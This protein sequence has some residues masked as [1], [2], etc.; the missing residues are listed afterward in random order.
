V[1]KSLV[2]Q[3]DADARGEPRFGMLE[4]IREFALERLEASGE[5]PEARRRH[6]EHFVALAEEAAP[7]LTRTQGGIWLNRL[8]VEHDN[9]RAALVW[10]D[11]A[12]D[13]NM[14]ARLAASLWWFWW[15]RGHFEARRWL[16]RALDRATAHDARLALLDGA[17]NMALFQ[18]EHAKS[19]ELWS[20]MVAIGRTCGNQ[21]AVAQS[22]VARAL[23]RQAYVMRIMGEMEQAVAASEE[24]IAI[25][26]QR[27]DSRTTAYTLHGVAQVAMGWHDL[28]GAVTAWEE[29]LVRFREVDDAF[30]VPHTLC[31]LGVVAMMRGR[32]DK[33]MP[34][35]SEALVLMRQRDDRFALRFGLMYMLVIAQRLGDAEQVL[36]LAREVLT[37]SI[38]QDSPVTA[39]NALDGI[40]WAV[41][42]N[43]DDAACAARLLGAAQALR[44]AAGVDLNPLQHPLHEDAVAATRAALGEE[45][46]A[47]AWA[48]GQAMTLEQAV[49]YALEAEASM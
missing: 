8:E 1:F 30:M 47:A 41:G 12:G 28:D 15:M 43:D 6:A 16:G 5:T 35:C 13:P 40:A 10:A 46:F 21:S 3:Q 7:W 20:E 4:T 11:V 44:S 26:R 32:L 18:D 29:A 19:I 48:E 9:L 23:A 42:R 38:E 14:L 24:A 39:S 27:G 25:A 49:A 31:N 22:A 17:A 2:R 34:L 45:A 33:A 36:A 37:L